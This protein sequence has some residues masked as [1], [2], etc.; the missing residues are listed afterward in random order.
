MHSETDTPDLVEITATENTGNDSQVQELQPEPS[1]DADTALDTPEHI[2]EDTE[3]EKPK[4][5][6]AQ[7]RIQQLAREKAELARELDAVKAQQQAPPNLER[8]RIETFETYDQYEEAL[9]NYRIG[10]AEQQVLSKLEHHQFEQSQRQRQTEFQVAIDRVADKLPN[11][12]EVVTSGIARQ[13]PM[14]ITLDELAE[15]FGYDAETQVKLLYDIASDA[16]FHAQV[17]GASKLRAARLLSERV[18]S[19]A[20][21]AASKIPS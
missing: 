16:A 1:T 21:K 15:A 2:P 13:F 18:D 20:Q 7:E 8:P 11:F 4:K 9:D 12:D 10:K 14:P 5:N 6:R 17:S 3:P 19:F